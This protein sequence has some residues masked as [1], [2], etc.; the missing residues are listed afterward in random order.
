[1]NEGLL[2]LLVIVATIGAGVWVALHRD[3][4]YPERAQP[5]A[6]S[7]VRT[8]KPRPM[9]RPAQVARPAE[10]V[11]KPAA[12][13][14]SPV[15]RIATPESDPEMIA[16]RALAKLIAADLITETAALQTVFDV[17]AGSSKRYK[18][19]QA[20]LKAAQAELESVGEPAR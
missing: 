6:R 7:R 20:K 2:A 17:K 10:T 12:S 14:S 9:H 1:M 16:L 8:A 15:S 11:A 5:A 18:E 19:V 3:I 4:I 13:V